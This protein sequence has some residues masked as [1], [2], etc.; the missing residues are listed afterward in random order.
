TYVITGT[1]SL[2]E[3]VAKI[4]DETA[5]TAKLNSDG[6]MVLTAVNAETITIDS[7][8]TAATGTLASAEFSLVVT[9]T[10]SDNRG[11]RIEAGSGLASIEQNALGLNI[12]DNDGNW[13]GMSVTGTASINAGDLIINGVEIG[14]IDA[15]SNAAA[16]VNA[17][18]KALND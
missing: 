9:D 4:N 1:S 11:V 3:L 13:V 15:A 16:Q 6:K 17:V 8:Q 10:S 14:D 12:Q 5:V 18:I 2:Q 7:D